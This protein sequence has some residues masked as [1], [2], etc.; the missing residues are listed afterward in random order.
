MTPAERK[1]QRN[2]EAENASN[3]K[4]AK[5]DTNEKYSKYSDMKMKKGGDPYDQFYK[6][7]TAENIADREAVINLPKRIYQGVKSLFSPA[8]PRTLAKL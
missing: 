5:A 4:A 6:D 3:V 1:L 2:Y 8:M 7:M